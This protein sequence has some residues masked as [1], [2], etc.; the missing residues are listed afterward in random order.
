MIH[1]LASIAISQMELQKYHRGKK[2]T[3]RVITPPDTVNAIMAIVKDEEVTAVILQLYHQSR[4][5]E[6]DTHDILRPNMVLVVKEPFFKA[7]GD[8]AYS[9]RVDHVSDVVWLQRTDPRIL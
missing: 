6:I 7:A 4:P 5:S 9:L 2:V 3:L 8:W 1:D